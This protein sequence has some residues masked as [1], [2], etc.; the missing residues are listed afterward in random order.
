MAVDLESEDL[1]RLLGQGEGERPD[2]GA[3]FEDT[4]SRSEPG[5]AGDAPGGVR[6]GQEVLAESPAGTHPVGGEQG[7]D[8]SG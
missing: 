1:A 2:A 8:V 7:A 6:V 4:S 3:D 5:Q